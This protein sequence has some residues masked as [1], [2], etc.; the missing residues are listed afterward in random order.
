M[1]DKILAFIDGIDYKTAKIVYGDKVTQG[2]QWNLTR[3]SHPVMEVIYMTDAKAYIK[4]TEQGLHSTW[5]DVVVYPAGTAHQEYVDLNKNQKCMYIWLDIKSDIILTEAFTMK[6]RN[7][8]LYWLINEIV[9]LSNGV[10]GEEEKQLI[11]LYIQTMFLHMKRN[12]MDKDSKKDVVEQAM[13]YMQYH[14]ADHLTIEGLAAMLYMNPTYLCRLFKKK[15][16][17][18]P[19]QYLIELRLECAKKLLVTTEMSVGEIS[20]YIGITDSKY[21]SKLFKK[22]ENSTPSEYRLKGKK[23][24]PFDS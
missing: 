2:T 20:E 12:V 17:M 22:K 23:S 16:E 18:T 6:D 5:C 10:V 1:K 14:Y 24:T 21:F 11:K 4:G 15:I 7:G 19:M 8:K 3:H 9:D 13:H